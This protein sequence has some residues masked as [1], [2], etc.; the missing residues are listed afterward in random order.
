MP[1]KVR[2]LGEE[3][4]I[5]RIGRRQ[6]ALRGPRKRDKPLLVI[7]TK[8]VPSR[9]VYWLEVALRFAEAAREMRGRPLEEVIANIIEKCSG[10]R[11]LTKDI[12]E[13]RKKARYKQADANI[14]RMRKEL[15]EKKKA[16]EE[17]EKKGVTEVLGYY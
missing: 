2:A 10:K 4:S 17:A 1:I 9:T 3:V 12:I 14:E 5:M 11:A 7:K 16:L 15:E 13:A 8:S 6:L